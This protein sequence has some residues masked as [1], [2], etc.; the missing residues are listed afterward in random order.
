MTEYEEE[1]V[2]RIRELDLNQI[3]PNSDSLND[4]E[5]KGRKYIV[6]GKP[7]FGKSNLIGSIMYAKSDVI[8]VAMVMSGSEDVDPFFRNFVPDTFIYNEYDPDK[9]KNLITRQKLAMM[10]NIPN[11]WVMAVFDDVSDDLSIFNTP[12]IHG[13]FKRSRHWKMLSIWAL[14][15]AMDIKPVIRNNVD[16]IFIL[17][18]AILENRQKLYKN[19]CSIVPDFT[20]FC[21]LMDELTTDHSALFI[22]NTKTT[23]NWQ[24]CVYYYKAPLMRDVKFKF[25]CSEYWQFHKVRYNEKEKNSVEF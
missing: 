1:G 17:R 6:I 20:T 11:P 4:V 22:D 5:A 12:L 2:I 15:Y 7:G 23:N 9:L 13:L 25:G 21:L 24:D 19:F 3:H 16:G 14:Q 8:P 18:D 10:F